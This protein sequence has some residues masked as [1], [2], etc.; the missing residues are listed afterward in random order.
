MSAGCELCGQGNLR[1]RRGDYEVRWPN[2]VRRRASVVHQALWYEC[3]SCSRKVVPPE[4][5]RRVERLWY[6]IEGLMTPEEMLDKRSQLGLTQLEFARELGVGDKTYTRW[7][8]GTRIQ[9]RAMDALMREKFEK[10]QLNS[11]PVCAFQPMVSASFEWLSDSVAGG[12]IWDSLDFDAAV[13]NYP[14]ATGWAADLS[15]GTSTTNTRD[16]DCEDNELPFA[17]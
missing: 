3:D 7:E 8:N 12:E 9:L 6:Q 17:A 10:L 11:P 15:V 2:S 13:Q 1:E 14:Q 16:R 4:L 5:S